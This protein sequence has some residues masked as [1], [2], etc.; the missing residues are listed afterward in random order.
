V[1]WRLVQK[2]AEL[3]RLPLCV[4]YSACTAV[5]LNA[6]LGMSRPPIV[7]RTNG[8]D[9]NSIVS[10]YWSVESGPSKKSW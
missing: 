1:A 7:L 5:E 2:S 6:T 8:L 4:T 3:V 10:V 9:S